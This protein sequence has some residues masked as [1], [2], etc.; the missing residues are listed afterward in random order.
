MCGCGSQDFM[1]SAM[2]NQN[3]YDVG[4]GQLSSPMMFGTDSMNTLGSETE[5]GSMHEANEPKGPM[6]EDID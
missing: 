2:P 4:P 3:V 5:E 1:G 6:G